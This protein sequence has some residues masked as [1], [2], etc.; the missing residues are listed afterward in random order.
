MIRAK[1]FWLYLCEDLNYR[2]FAG[3]PCVGL[4]PLYDKMNS[5][6][7]H[8]IPAVKENTALGMANGARLAGVKSCILMDMNKLYNIMDWILSFNLEY[9]V[10][11]LI[12]AY[13]DSYDLRFNK[14]LSSY[15]IPH[16]VMKDLKDLK[17][18]ANKSEKLAKPCIC[19]IGKGVIEK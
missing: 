11:I 9:K 19:I 10:P 5:K 18:I 2:F 3:V 7:M 4:K 1:E 12:V 15:K 8:Y 14:V 17:F 6:I 13:G 16:R